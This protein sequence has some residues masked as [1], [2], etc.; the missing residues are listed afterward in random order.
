M[1]TVSSQRPG[2]FSSYSVIGTLGGAGA[3]KAAAVVAASETGAKL[4]VKQLGR[5]SDA[6]AEYGAAQ[7]SML[8]TLAKILI[9]NGVSDIYCISVGATPTASDYESAFALLSGLQGVSGVV[10]DAGT[11]AVQQALAGRLM[12]DAAANKERIGF[13][14]VP[15]DGE[16]EAAARAVNCER[17][18]LT[19]PAVAFEGGSTQSAAYLAAAYCALALRSEDPA[20]NLNLSQAE[21]S[22]TFPVPY[23]E[24]SLTAL[25][26]A[27]VSVFEQAGE[28]AE[29]I[30]ALTTKT[31][32][33]GLQGNSFREL[34]TVRIIDDVIPGIRTL[35]KAQLRG[36]K[37]TASARDAIRT[38]VACE[39]SRKCFLGII[40]SFE[41]PVITVKENEPTVCVVEV[42]FAVVYGLHRIDI[43]AHVT[44]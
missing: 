9:L 26:Q 3:S 23:G 6:V 34:S 27:G 31:S 21:G 32:E 30:R 39:L 29:L 4:T 11:L 38:Q 8:T 12:A 1:S 5:L 25:L 14:G 13:M 2:V 24:D 10:C 20:A 28:K 41:P 40:D 35:L 42:A 33:N 18:C 44:V 19:A 15:A 16:P 7:A 36:A 43:V 37:N 22:Y 17:V